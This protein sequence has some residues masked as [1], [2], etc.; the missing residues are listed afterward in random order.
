VQLG[1]V[2]ND[3]VLVLRGLQGGEKVVTAGVHMLHAGQRVK[4]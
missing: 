2:H 4:P 3:N 1:A